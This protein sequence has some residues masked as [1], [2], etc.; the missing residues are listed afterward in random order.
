MSVAARDRWWWTVRQARSTYWAIVRY[1][2]RESSAGTVHVL[3][4][5]GVF[6]AGCGSG[7]DEFYDSGLHGG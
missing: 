2:L 3:G 4:A 1:G 5:R 6:K 7:S